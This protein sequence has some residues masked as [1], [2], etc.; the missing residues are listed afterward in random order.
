MEEMR[1]A[2]RAWELHV[3]SLAQPKNFLILLEEK[4]EMRRALSFA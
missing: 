3:A 4:R 2:V 1:D